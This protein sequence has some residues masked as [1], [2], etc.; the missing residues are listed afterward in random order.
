MRRLP[1]VTAAHHSGDHHTR[2]KPSRAAIAQIQRAGP[3]WN[4]MRALYTSRAIGMPNQ[5]G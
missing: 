4:H 5:I 2:K 3:D 1:G